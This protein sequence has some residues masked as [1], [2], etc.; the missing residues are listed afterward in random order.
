VPVGAGA[1]QCRADLGMCAMPARYREHGNHCQDRSCELHL[2]SSFVP[3]YRMARQGR[4]PS[5]WPVR[6]SGHV[7]PVQVIVPTGLDRDGEV[8]VP[9]AQ[10]LGGV[11][12][13]LQSLG[14]PAR[15]AC[16]DVAIR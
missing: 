7:V 15:A 2:G 1:L 10:E 13:G 3:I 14:M 5:Q 12:G 6:L 16:G 4:R 11:G 8:E 9:G